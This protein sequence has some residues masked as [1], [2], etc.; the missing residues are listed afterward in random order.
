MTPV[1]KLT[2]KG[3]A[4]YIA[5]SPAAQRKLLQDF[6]YPAADEPFAMRLYYRE[7]K[8]CLKQYIRDQRSPE[9]LREQAH[10]LTGTLNGQSPK[11]VER[12]RQNAR[13]VIAFE[14]FFSATGVELL[15]TPRF[16]FT[17]HG[18]TISV[19]PDLSLLDGTRKRLIKIQYGGKRLADPS[20][21]VMTQC[22][23]DAANASSYGL[24]ASSCVYLDLP[25]E[26]VHTAPR[27][28]KRTLQDVKAACETISQVWE[29]IPPPTRSKRSAAA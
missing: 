8:D 13:A 7:A 9:W 28:G 11:S 12:L 21:R 23:L 5:S 6:K 1:I 20:I 17:H 27:A 22:M 16:R 19:V 25:R 2:L 14:R 18:V 29:S 15:D 26:A 3:L 4:K 10:Q 24:S